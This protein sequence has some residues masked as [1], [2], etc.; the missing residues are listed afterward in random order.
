MYIHIYY[1]FCFI[2]MYIYIYA[3]RGVPCK[4]ALGRTSCAIGE[5]SPS[6]ECVCVSGFPLLLYINVQRS[7]GGLVFK[8]HRLL[9]HSA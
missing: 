1:L 7:R 6:L 5:R 3:G 8:A 9:Y 2:Y 4:P